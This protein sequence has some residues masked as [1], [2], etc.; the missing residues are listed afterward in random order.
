MAS[1][2]YM[3]DMLER[4]SGYG[5]FLKYMQC[6]MSNSTHLKPF[7]KLEEVDAHQHSDVTVLLKELLIQN[8]ACKYG[9]SNCTS[10]ASNEYRFWMDVYNQTKPDHPI[11]S[12]NVKATV[13]CN[14]VR[15]GGTE[16]WNHAWRHYVETNLAS[17]RSMM[18]DALACTKEVWLL[19]TYLERIFEKNSEIRLQ[20]AS[21][22]FASIAK[23]V[24]GKSLAF[25]FLVN[26][27]TAIKKRFGSGISA[28]DNFIGQF[29]SF[30][31]PSELSRVQALKEQYIND[32]GSGTRAIDQVIESIEINI[33]WMD[34]HEQEVTDWFKFEGS[35]LCAS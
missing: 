3:G 10:A 26:H 17:E 9:V 27:F 22:A 21:R 30:N 34:L 2:D 13:Y 19:S 6:L 32:L 33:E 12:P 23:S 5:D 7:E 15:N 8:E 4:T 25:D 14:G 11:L 28:M 16:E 29:G 1:F 24:V 35:T 31:T 18:L 20:D